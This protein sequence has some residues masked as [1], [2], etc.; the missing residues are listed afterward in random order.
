MT[1]LIEE[2]E[3]MDNK[4][5]GNSGLRVSQYALGSVPFSG[6]NGF[7]NAGVFQRKNSIT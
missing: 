3:P 2:D 5:L 7:E 1:G 4:Q 6:T